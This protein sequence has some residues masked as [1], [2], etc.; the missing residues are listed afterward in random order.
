MQRKLAVGVALGILLI[1]AILPPI[2]SAAQ[3][4][5]AGR[6]SVVGEYVGKVTLGAEEFPLQAQVFPLGKN[7]FQINVFTTG[8]ETTQITGEGTTRSLTF[9]ATVGGDE[10]SGKIENGALTAQSASGKAEL[11]KFTRRSPT[12]GQ[13]PP[14]GAKVLMPYQRGEKTN[15]DAWTNSNWL[16]RDDGSVQAQ[17]GNNTTKQEF[18]DCKLHVEFNIPVE[19]AN[20]G[21]GRG[22]SGVYLE[23]RYECQV[24]DSFGLPTSKVDCGA[25]YEIAAPRE[26]VALPPGQW[27]TYDIT[28]RAPRFEGEKVV[29][30]PTMNVVWNGVLVHENQEVPG[31]TRAA[32]L[33]GAAPKGPLMI[34]DHGNPVRY[35]NIW[36]V[37]LNDQ[38]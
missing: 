19:P 28:F 36:L 16:I 25:I 34:Q 6:G 8:T 21:Q 37:E 12:L 20:R 5:G 13:A 30:L 24:L 33:T 31:P 18:G 17:K 32:G 22:N 9:K 38:K 3:G 4:R 26:N 10:W 15:L 35:R 2:A 23:N 7:Q 11:R 29:K 1:G 14:E 27:Q